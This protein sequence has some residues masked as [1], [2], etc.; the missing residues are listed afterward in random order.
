MFS[1]SKWIAVLVSL[2]ALICAAQARDYAGR[3]ELKRSDLTGTNMEVIVS[4]S[5]TKPGETLP[6]H[7]H[8]GEEAFYVLDDTIVELPDGKQNSVK[9]GNAG[10]SVRDVPQ[11]GVKVVGDKALRLLTVHIVDKGKPLYD[12]PK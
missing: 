10:I 11:G 7:F 6:R 1:F 4:I 3:K 2:A 5:E 12:S 8:N 9:A